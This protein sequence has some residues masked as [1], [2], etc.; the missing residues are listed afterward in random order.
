M[1]E[2]KKIFFTILTT[3]LCTGMIA[4]AKAMIDVEKLK[5]KMEFIVDDIRS[6]RSDVAEIKKLLYNR[7]IK[8]E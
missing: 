6:I 7:R 5:T 4:T 3:I 8:D 1:E 2:F